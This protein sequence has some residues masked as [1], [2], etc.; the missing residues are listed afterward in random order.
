MRFVLAVF[1]AACAPG[2]WPFSR[3][4]DPQYLAL[5]L[6]VIACKFALGASTFWSKEASRAVPQEAAIYY[7]HILLFHWM[8]LFCDTEHN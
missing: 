2:V 4:G 7:C 5:Y 8:H 3:V 6:G 1:A